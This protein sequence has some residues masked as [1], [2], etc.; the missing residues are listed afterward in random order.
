[1]TA[2]LWNSTSETWTAPLSRP[3][4]KP[5]L[6]NQDDVKT[7]VSGSESVNRIEAMPESRPAPSSRQMTADA[8]GARLLI[9]AL[10][11]RSAIAGL[12]PQAADTV[13]ER[14]RWNPAG[15]PMRAPVPLDGP[16]PIHA[17]P[18]FD[19]RNAETEFLPMRMR[20][21]LEATVLKHR[22]R[23]RSNALLWSSAAALIALGLIASTTDTAATVAARIHMWI[24][25]ASEA[26]PAAAAD[27]LP[28]ALPASMPAA[29]PRLES[30]VTQVFAEPAKPPT[31]TADSEK[32]IA[33]PPRVTKP[34]RLAT[35]RP[36]RK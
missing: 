29:M 17:S 9:P 12:E 31:V 5:V 16:D 6:V 1:M 23:F 34:T 11:L 24:Q 28:A 2:V 21:S 15:V 35:V 3:A 4:R 25:P 33:T 19:E 36:S 20:S 32:T 27:S 14:P 22:S 8:S 10:S 30:V 7:K 18:R 26:I 13:D